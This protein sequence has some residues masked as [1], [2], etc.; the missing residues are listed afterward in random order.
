MSAEDSNEAPSSGPLS[1][2]RVVDIGHVLAGP[3]AATLLGDMGADV[4]KVENPRGGDT[5]RALSPKADGV[6]VWWKV[7]G[8]NKRCVA[9]DLKVEAAKDVLLR[10]IDDADV[11][12]ENFRAGT[13]ERMGFEPDLLME[14]NPRLI[15]LRIS[16]Y[17]QGPLGTGRSGYG[18]IG[19]AMSGTANLTGEAD[20][21]PLHVGFSLGDAT[22]GLMGAYGVLAALHER[23]RS[24]RG[25]IVDL[26]LFESLFR[27]IEWQLPMADLLDRVPKR[28]GNQFP[29]GYAVA[30]SFQSSDSQ[31]V[32]L[33]AAT[34]KSIVRVL[35]TVGGEELAGDPRFATAE[36]REEPANLSLIEQAIQDWAGA[37][38]GE[39]IM[40]AFA[41]T[42][43]AAGYVYDAAMML[44][45][46]LF[47]EREAVVS[48]SDP[49]LGTLRQP[50]IIPKLHRNPGQIRWSGAEIGAHTVEVMR[51]VLG[52]SEDEIQQLEDDSAFG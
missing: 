45:D 41:D 44:D 26:A 22:S 39:E 13:L 46:P 32:A 2:I 51:D 17:G 8:R 31:W 36:G 30:G 20:G 34:T 23:D 10:L 50:G 9:L 19:E 1:D 21:R 28:Q 38:T 12:V 7:A 37:R 14:R 49:Q 16:G 47:A 3:F 35:M 48:T 29:I 11:L 33:S 25:D 27:M 40:A 24:G 18:R 52:L 5:L 42:D 15:I 4:I 6:P 43:V